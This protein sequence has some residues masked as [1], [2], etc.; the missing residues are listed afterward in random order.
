MRHAAVLSLAAAAFAAA[1]ALA[2]AGCGAAGGDGRLNAAQQAFPRARQLAELSAGDRVQVW[3]IHGDPGTLGYLAETLCQARSG[4]FRL[5]A[6]MDER[7]TVRRV[8]IHDYTAQRGHGVMSAAFR[9]QFEGRRPENV[10]TLGEEI[11]AVS[12]ATISSDAAVAGMKRILRTAAAQ[13]R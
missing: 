6:L 12:G 10:G 1:L 8:G 9:R 3:A 4:T 5:R 7:L 2:G 11:D 13:A